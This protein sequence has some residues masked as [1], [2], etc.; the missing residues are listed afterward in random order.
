VGFAKKIF[1]IIRRW[2]GDVS[3][4]DEMDENVESWG[5][6]RGQGEW[7]V[8]ITE[9]VFWTRFAASLEESKRVDEEFLGKMGGSRDVACGVVGVVYKEELEFGF[10][11]K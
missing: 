5:I 1:W 4:D 3:A 8:G 9:D 10:V 7:S 11:A 6:S 2:T